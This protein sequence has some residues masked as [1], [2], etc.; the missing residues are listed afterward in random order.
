M[1]VVE[2]VVDPLL[3]TVDAQC[4]HWQLPVVPSSLQP[5]QGY[6]LDIPCQ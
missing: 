6:D 4:S 3:V 1:V 2:C 5:R